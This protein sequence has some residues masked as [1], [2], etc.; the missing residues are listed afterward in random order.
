L[1]A[2]G[3]FRVQRITVQTPSPVQYA[4]GVSQAYDASPPIWDNSS[5]SMRSPIWRK[6]LILGLLLAAPIILGL[7]CA[8]RRHWHMHIGRNG[9]LGLPLLLIALGFFIWVAKSTSIEMPASPTQAKVEYY[10]IP[11]NQY[12]G[13]IPVAAQRESR[14]SKKT[15]EIET[16]STS[17]PVTET[18]AQTAENP[19]ADKP[20]PAESLPDWVHSSPQVKDDMYYEVVPLKGVVDPSIRYEMMN[21]KLKEVTNHYIDDVLFHQPGASSFTNLSP[22]YLREKCNG[23]EFESRSGS[24]DAYFRLKFDKD[25]RG[26]VE[27][28]Y[29]TVVAQDHLQQLGVAGLIAFAGLGGLYVF[30][31]A[32]PKNAGGKSATDT[33][34]P[35]STT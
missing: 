3:L 16:D 23:G 6:M 28:Q 22:D 10:S 18:T 31:R 29:R 34:V 9:L 19:D 5:I 17:T 11:Q 14:K 30:L 15:A 27:R 2:L 8:Y 7:R 32:A 21:D 13:V 25:F 26:L 1:I 4:P 20:A 33:A 12:Q 24:G 35:H